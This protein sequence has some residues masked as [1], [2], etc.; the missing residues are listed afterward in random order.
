MAYTSYITI[1]GTLVGEETNGV[2]RNY[3]TDALGSVVTTTLNGVAEN[4]YRYKPY[5]G[6]LAKTGTAA[7]PSFLW[8]GGSGYRA[9][10]LPSASHYVR[11]RHY[12]GTAAQWTTADPRWPGEPP[13]AYAQ[14]RPASQADPSGTVCTPMPVTNQGC[15]GQ[16]NW[17]GVGHCPGGHWTDCPPAPPLAAACLASKSQVSCSAVAT[18]IGQLAQACSA[19]CGGAKYGSG[20]SWD[21]ATIC[22]LNPPACCVGCTQCCSTSNVNTTGTPLQLCSNFCLIEHEQTHQLQCSESGAKCALP[23]NPECCPY[24]VQAMC[25]FYLFMGQCGWRNPPPPDYGAIPALP[26]CRVAA[27][28]NG[29]NS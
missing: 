20:A 25:M 8:N 22:C 9:T 26:A 10:T 1:D 5:G 27:A 6:L 12:S 28:S 2:M 15:C 13:T 18:I 14:G 11:R 29:C 21:A 16:I 4:T 7:D 17:S 24:Y 3:G 23:Q 19:G